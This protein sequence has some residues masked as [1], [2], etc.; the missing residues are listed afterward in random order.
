MAVDPLKVALIMVVE[1]KKTIWN[2]TSSEYYRTDL[3][4]VALDCTRLRSNLS[5]TGYSYSV[6]LSCAKFNN[7]I[8]MFSNQCR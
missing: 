8:T 6:K 1:D 2:I 4:H 5:E 3:K 7:N